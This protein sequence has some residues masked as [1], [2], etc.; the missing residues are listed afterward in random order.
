MSLDQGSSVGCGGFGSSG[1][2][3]GS[4]FASTG[5]AGGRFR[6]SG[7]PSGAFVTARI[8]KKRSTSSSDMPN[9]TQAVMMRGSV[10]F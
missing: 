7:R 5:A 1:D 4:P 10:N 9:W 8:L 3:G 6:V 2:F